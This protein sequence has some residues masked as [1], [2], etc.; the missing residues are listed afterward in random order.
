MNAKLR[1]CTTLIVTKNDIA[2]FALVGI[3]ALVCSIFALAELI[4][5]Y[6]LKDYMTPTEA[7][8]WLLLPGC[9]IFIIWLMTHRLFWFLLFLITGI[10]FFIA[11][12]IL[13][14]N[15]SIGPA[16]GCLMLMYI[17]FGIAICIWL[18]E[19]EMKNKL[20]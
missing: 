20:V 8:L 2:Y 1:Y 5:D 16:I 17:P 11:S 19:N 18:K 13:F 9:G 6:F 14:F 12:I 3:F 10:A 7:G 15:A 4:F